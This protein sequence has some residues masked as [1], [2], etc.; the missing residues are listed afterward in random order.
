M[1]IEKIERRDINFIM[2]GERYVDSYPGE[3]KYYLKIGD[4]E[5]ELEKEDYYRIEIRG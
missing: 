4:K 1:N 3:T 2:E 5:I